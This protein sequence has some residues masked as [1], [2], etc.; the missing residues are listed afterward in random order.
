MIRQFKNWTRKTSATLTVACVSKEWYA[1][2]TEGY[3]EAHLPVSIAAT[4]IPNLRF[5]ALKLPA[6]AKFNVLKQHSEG[7]LPS[8]VYSLK[9]WSE[10][11]VIERRDEL[12]L[13]V[14]TPRKVRDSR[15]SINKQLT[16]AV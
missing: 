12:R 4:G 7:R 11:S 10:A 1:L 6:L 3:T 13:V 8:L 9:Q 15:T 16:E 2:H 14:A 5:E